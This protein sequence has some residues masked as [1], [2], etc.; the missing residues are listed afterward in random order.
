MKTLRIVF[1]ALLALVVL[2]LVLCL[3]GPARVKVSRTMEIK[4]PATAIFA[5]LYDFREWPKWSPWQINDT[6][7]VNTYSGNPY[8]V[9]AVH[10][11]ASKKSGSGRQEIMSEDIPKNLNTKLSINDWGGDYAT[12]FNLEEKTGCTT[13]VT[14]TMEGGDKIPFFSRGMM[15]FMN[16][17]IG[18]DY[19]EGLN[20]LKSLSEAYM[21]ELPTSYR[22]VDIAEQEYTGKT[23]AA[24]RQRVGMGS[25][26]LFL[27]EGYALLDKTL[28]EAGVAPAG[29]MGALFYE[30]DEANGQVDMAVVAPV[31]PGF[32]A[33][34]LETITLAA[35]KVLTTD[36][37]GKYMGSVNAHFAIEDYLRDRCLKE[38]LPVIEEYLT[39]PRVQSDTAKWQIRIVCFYE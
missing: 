39:D 23:Y 2:Y 26:Q 1:G 25:I 34:G 31:E 28:S 11:W 30:W 4:A 19:K 21:V 18:G 15:L 13:L 33:P 35:G 8:G 17:L 29:D 9:G 10:S 32:S 6:T 14:W 7:I 16:R 20:N 36:Y 5:Y 24:F 37:E 22:G 27:S 3:A 12:S 38:K